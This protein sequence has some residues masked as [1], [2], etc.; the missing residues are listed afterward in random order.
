M[1]VIIFFTALGQP[2]WCPGEKSKDGAEDCGPE[3]PYELMFKM[4]AVGGGLSLVNTL[5][6][7]LGCCIAGWRRR[8]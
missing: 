1:W 5:V 3:G 7:L 2:G 6:G 4:A 8:H